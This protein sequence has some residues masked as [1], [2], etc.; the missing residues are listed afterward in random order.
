MS[1]LKFALV[2]KKYV[3]DKSLDKFT[4]HSTD[5]QRINQL[6]FALLFLEYNFSFYTRNNKIRHRHIIA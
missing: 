2:Y 1:G 3:I 5:P 4:E 6:N